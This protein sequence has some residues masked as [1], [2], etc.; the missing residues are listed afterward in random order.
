MEKLVF[1]PLK[2]TEIDVR[3]QSVTEKGCILLLYKDAR[4]DMNILDETVG[5]MNWKREHTRDNANCIVSLWDEEKYQWVSKED[6]GTESNTEKEKG[7]ASD[8][9]KRACFNWGIGRELYTSPF[10][11]VKKDDCNMYSIKGN[12]GKDIWKCNDKF[13][14][15][16]IAYDEN[17][18]ITG[19]SIKNNNTKKRVFLMKP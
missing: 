8:S 12:N 1:R 9:F 5:P 10:I 16:K 13:E 7:Q 2:E 14:V 6:T 17:K 4:C 3:V 15:E 19:L 11:W 18:N